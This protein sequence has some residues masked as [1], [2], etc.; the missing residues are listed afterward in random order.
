MFEAM[1]MAQELK[2][3]AALAEHQVYSVPSTHEADRDQLLTPVP[4]DLAPSS[5]LC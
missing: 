3:L 5:N 1:A 2:I 4:G